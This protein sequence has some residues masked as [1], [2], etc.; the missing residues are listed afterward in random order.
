MAKRTITEYVHVKVQFT[1]EEKIQTVVS[2][3]V[4]VLGKLYDKYRRSVE[5]YKRDGYEIKENLDDLSFV[6]VKTYEE[7]ENA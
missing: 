4:G 3:S 1:E 6:A 5:L 7:D 2:N